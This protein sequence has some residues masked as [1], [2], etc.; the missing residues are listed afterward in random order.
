MNMNKLL[1]YI[2]LTLL[3]LT[4]CASQKHHH[5]PP[6]D[7]IIVY[8]SERKMLLVH[9]GDIYRVYD[10]GLGQNPDGHKQKRGDYRT[11]E[12][13]YYIDGRNPYSKFYLSLHISYPD[14]EDIVR[15]KKKGVDP[16]DHIVIHGMRGK[17]TRQD[18]LEAGDWTEGCIAVSN[19]EMH[20]LW[21]LIDVG[22]PISIYP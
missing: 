2:L 7:E 21:H 9:E 10:I 3:L 8:K 4:G 19:K 18:F 13:E 6:A 17:G 11:P 5:A 20:E 12:G 16:G 15:A 1:S 22:T 14:E